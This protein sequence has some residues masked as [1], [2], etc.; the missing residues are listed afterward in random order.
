MSNRVLPAR[1][2][3]PALSGLAL[4]L[5]CAGATADDGPASAPATPASDA[6]GSD[7]AAARQALESAARQVGELH[8]MLAQD[9][10]CKWLEPVARTALQAT[11][12]ERLAWLDA[13]GADT[14]QARQQAE[15][16]ARASASKLD[17]KSQQAQTLAHA[18]QFGTWQMRITWA[19]RAEALLDQNDRPAWMKGKSKVSAQRDDLAQAL[20]LL[21]SRHSAAVTRARKSIVPDAQKYL[22]VRCGSGDASCDPASAGNPAYAEAWVQQA[23]AY[24]AALAHTSDKIGQPPQGP[25]KAK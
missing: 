15:T 1:R 8:R 17:C 21:Q 4:A 22:A 2:L 14:A 25:G 20:S 23:E 11:L 9:E 5:A 10:R 12:Q 7:A 6:T 18:A 19:L 16:A 3:A 13:Q 24:A